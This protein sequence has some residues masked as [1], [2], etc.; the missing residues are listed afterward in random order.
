MKVLTEIQAGNASGRRVGWAKHVTGVDPEGKNGYA[1]SGEFIKTGREVELPEGAFILHVDP[2]GS[3]KNSRKEAYIT[4]LQADGSEERLHEGEY[5][6]RDE[7]ISLRQVVEGALSGTQESR[8]DRLEFLAQRI[9]NL[10][11]DAGEIG[12][13][14]LRQ[15]VSEARELTGE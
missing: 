4:R 8:S 3:V 13:G 14:M 1:F 9:A 7:F 5:D 11:P 6:W 15:L 2:A 12:E 10:N